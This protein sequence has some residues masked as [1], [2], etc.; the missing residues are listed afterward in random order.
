MEE[1]YLFVWRGDSRAEQQ[2]GVR[3]ELLAKGAHGLAEH[4]RGG[5]REKSE[6]TRARVK[7]RLAR[8]K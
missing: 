5:H 3:T 7:Q 6:Q 1:E 8:G 4:M 2:D